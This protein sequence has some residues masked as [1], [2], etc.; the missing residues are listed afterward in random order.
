MIGKRRRGYDLHRRDLRIRVPSTPTSRIFDGFGGDS[1]IICI[2]LQPM[3]STLPSLRYGGGRAVHVGLLMRGARTFRFASRRVG[4]GIQTPK[5]LLAQK[6][7]TAVRGGLGG[8]SSCFLAEHQSRWSGGLFGCLWPVPPGFRWQLQAGQVSREIRPFDQPRGCLEFT[9]PTY[10]LRSC[11]VQKPV[12]GNKPHSSL[13]KRNPFKLFE[14]GCPL[15][16]H[17][18]Q[19]KHIPPIDPGRRHAWPLD[20]GRKVARW[21]DFLHGPRGFCP[22]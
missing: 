1:H 2:A 10:A 14:C 6:S 9:K 16:S 19:E 17:Q 3:V 12:T 13:G 20:E 21:T 5:L 8:L 15:L 22:R 11:L 4:R 7:R 18:T